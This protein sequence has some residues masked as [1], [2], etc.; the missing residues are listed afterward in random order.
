MNT[1]YAGRDTKLNP[2]LALALSSRDTAP[3]AALAR[4][5]GPA[6][7]VD[8]EA[9]RRGAV[10]LSRYVREGTQAAGF[11]SAAWLALGAAATL[12]LVWMLLGGGR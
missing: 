9:A 12:E 4:R 6:R 10:C 7:P 11:E 8:P 1:D 2:M 5:E 3:A